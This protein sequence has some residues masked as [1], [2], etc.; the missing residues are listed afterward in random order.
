MGSVTI[1][2]TFGSGGS[3]I[4]PAVAKKLALPFVDRAIPPAL[5]AKI[6]EPLVAALADDAEERSAAGRLLNSA[7]G[8]TGLFA[9]VP[10]TFEELGVSP[11]VAQTEEAIRQVVRAGG[12]VILGKGGVFVLKGRPGVLHVRLDA[13]VEARRRAAMAR[14]GLDYKT[15]ARMQQATDYARRAYISHFYPREGAWEDPRHYHMILDSTAIALDTCVEIISR[16][17]KDLFANSAAEQSSREQ[18]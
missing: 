9:G 12:A 17:A 6:H 8:H 15:A 16:A 18:G 4:G 13:P 5:A 7:L 11:D 3:V 1:A 2:A 14:D 10:R